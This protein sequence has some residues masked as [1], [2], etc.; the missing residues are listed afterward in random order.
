MAK[1]MVVAYIDT[2]EQLLHT[3]LKCRE[4]GWRELDA[5]M[6]YPVHGFEQALGIRKSWIPA[7]AK[8]MLVVG[9]LLGF[10]FQAWTSATDWPINVGGKPLVS[11]PAFIPVVFECGVLLAG[12]TTFFALLYAGRLFPGKYM[13]GKRRTVPDERLT[14]DR[15]ALLVPVEINGSRDQI[16][17]FLR[18]CGIHEFDQE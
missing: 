8:T 6:P 13:F 3:G 18:E 4:R 15:F 11:W 17:G 7:A 2:P 9:A 12:L 14:N 16:E 5:L 10:A 1:E